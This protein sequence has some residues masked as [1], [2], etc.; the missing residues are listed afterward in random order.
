MPATDGK[1]ESKNIKCWLCT[2]PHRLMDCNNFKG[3]TID[4]R[5][6]YIKSERLCYNFFSKGHNAKDCKSKYRCRVDSCNKRHHSLIHTDKEIKSNQVATEE[7]QSDSITCNKIYDRD[8]Q[9]NLTYLQVLPINVSNGDKTFRA[10]ALLDSGSDS[11]L[12][13]KT[14]ADKLNLCGGERSLTITNVM[15]TKLKIKSKLV[16][17]S[18]SSNFHP[19]RI[20]ISNAWVVDNLNLPSYTMTKDFPH[21]RD[22]D[23]ERTSDK[24]ISILIGADMPELHLHRDTR[25]GDKDQPVGLL[26]T[27]GWV[28]MG[29]KSKTN[30]SNS[31]A[32]FN[33]LNRDAEMLDKSIERFWQTESYGVLKKDDPNLMPKVDRRAIN[34]LNSTSSKIDNHHTVGLLWKEDKTILPN[35]RSTAM[36]RF[37]GLEKRFKRDPLLAEK[38]KETVNQYIEKGHATKLT[39]DTA[40]QTS[41]ITNYI[42]HHAVTNPNK[43]GKIRVVFDAAAKH[44]GTSLNDKLLKGPDLLN[45]LIGLLIRFRK[46]KYA[47]IAD[48]EQMFHQIFVLEKDR[49]ALR[50][51]WRDTPSGKIDDYI[52]NVHLFGK[53]DSPCCANWSLKKTALDQKDIYPENIVLK[54]LDNFYMDDYLDSF[55]EKDSAISTIKDVI[56]ILSTGG[57]RLHKWIANSRE[58]LLS[59]PVSEVSSKIVNL[60]LDEIPIERALGLLWNPLNDLLQIKAVNKT[61][62]TSKRGVL[63]FI[64]SIFDPLGMLAPATLEP[65]LIIQE[66]WKRKLD[67]DEELPPDLKHR[68]NDWKA[69]LHELPSIEIP[70]WYGFKL[71]EESALELCVFTDVPSCTYGAVACLRFK[72]NSEFKCSFVIGKSRIEPIKESHFVNQS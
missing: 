42:P 50:F 23:L 62:P 68:W 17:F 13:S 15:S 39:D 45:S 46:G 61:L 70:R 8:K 30:L 25:I 14:L 38:Y 53:I 9:N 16:N 66:L 4:E 49:D 72:S 40:S 55:S 35:N 2:K 7:I 12:I 22:I 67:W 34:I 64:S 65:K 11:T 27:L 58:I 20:E 44:K 1:E 29:G 3:K 36:S 47:V 21:L 18:V 59:L 5:K 71:P 43:P 10:N 48:I 51:L 60:E 19:S 54:I 63:S 33:L 31:N 69:T 32:L 56:C 52:M 24:S 28:V 41:D 26:T 6:E 57:F 37:L